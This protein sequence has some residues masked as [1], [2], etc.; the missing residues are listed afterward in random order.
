MCSE[1]NVYMIVTNGMQ[2]FILSDTKAL[3]YDDKL[4]IMT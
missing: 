3:E 1:V 4:L 2:L